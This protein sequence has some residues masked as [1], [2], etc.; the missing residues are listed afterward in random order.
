MS[1]L[2]LRGKSVSGMYVR[3]CKGVHLDILNLTYH[4]KTKILGFEGQVLTQITS[5]TG[6]FKQN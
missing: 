1:L 5:E 3:I 4:V 2:L 6:V